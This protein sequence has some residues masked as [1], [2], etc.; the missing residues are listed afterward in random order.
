MVDLSAYK[1]EIENEIKKLNSRNVSE[2]P[3]ADFL[4]EI[5]A[6]GLVE[7]TVNPTGKIER[8]PDSQDKGSNKTGWYSYIEFSIGEGRVIGAGSYGSWRTGES[9]KWS[10][11]AQQKMTSR[12]RMEYFTKSQA[13]AEQAEIERKNNQ[14]NAAQKAQSIYEKAGEVQS[15]D[16][17]TRKKIDI[18]G[19]VRLSGENLCI[20]VQLDGKITSLEFI[21]PDGSKKFL[22]GGRKKGCYF[23][24]EGKGDA[25]YIAEGYS[26]AASIH[27]ATGAPVY[28][29][30]DA[31]NLYEVASN[32]KALG[33]HQNVIIACDNDDQNEYN[34]GAE[35]GRQAAE[36]LSLDFILPNQT[37]DFNDMHAEHG[38]DHLSAYLGK[39]EYEIYEG[40]TDKTEKDYET[41]KGA[42]G[43]IMDY[44][45]ATSGNDQPLFAIQCAIATCSVVLGRNFE[46]NLSN[47]SSL[48]MMNIGKSGTGK[49][50]AKK[51]LEKILD[52]C[53]IGHLVSGDGYTSGTAVISA[54]QARP[55]HVTI[56]D[57][58]SKYLQAAGNKNSNSHLMEA[59]AQL[60][61]AIGRL[62]GVM[63]P[64]AFSTMALT[65][66]KA[67][68][69]LE[70]RVVNPA[71]T[72][73]S[74][75]TPDDLF[76]TIDVSQVKD[77][78]LNRFIICVSDAKRTLRKHKE[79]VNVP[80]TIVRWVENIEERRGSQIEEAG[81]EPK[82]TTLNFS[83]DAMDAQT[84]FQLE[85]LERANDLERLGLSEMV[86]RSNE[87]AMRLALIH[88]LSR[89]PSATIVAEED[90]RWGIN[91]IAYNLNKV[92]NKLK[93]SVSGSEHEGHKKEILQGVRDAGK[94]GVTWAQM[95]KQPPFSKYKI[96]DL[97]DILKALTDASLVVDEPYSSG[98]K[99]R[100]TIKYLAIK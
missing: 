33:K 43:Q 61:Q 94:E 55:R 95:Q 21:K 88:A 54:L 93:I 15:H 37:G 92:I 59:N 57:E 48:F 73:L 96:K 2:N 68:E 63:R 75:T 14:N 84:E 99:G 56:I 12:E 77:G 86:S 85:C 35:K 89:D 60:M 27:M 22:T 10:S 79:P 74:M 98:G 78:F 46:T 69:V 53:K 91:W 70:M 25:A 24:I 64:K 67:Q 47:R 41:P 66:D 32:I 39:I 11:A 23:P 17:A 6:Y 8:V 52:A 50:H 42:L 40:K 51:T 58:F 30:F 38:L 62:D 16:Y 72:L 36:G 44:Y 49:E 71:I 9:I 100:P 97:K 82:M 20:P 45:N 28:V 5:Q 80:D 26:T 13:I 76:K 83:T 81:S 29:A 3:R 18:V 19:D 4:A 87:M 34:T 90:M 7:K 1:N 31:G 65:K